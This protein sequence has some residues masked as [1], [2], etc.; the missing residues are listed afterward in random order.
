MPVVGEP[1]RQ[2]IDRYASL[3]VFS[4]T[5]L[6]PRRLSVL[7]APDPN[8]S[9]RAQ[10]RQLLEPHGLTL[11]M[12]DPRT[13]YVAV[14]APEPED[15]PHSEAT[16]NPAPVVQPYIEEVTVYA[17]F[18]VD[19]TD[20]RQSLNQ[21]Q[22][23]LIP[24]TGGDTLRALRILPSV[25][26]DGL[27]AKHRIRG[28]DNNEVLYRLDGVDQY[29]PFHFADVHSLFTAVNPNIID[30]V[31]V[32]VSGFPS[33]FGTRMSGVVDLHLVE[34]ERPLHGT[35]EVSAL[36]AAADARG[37]AGKWSWLVSGRVSLIGDV[38]EVIKV[39][40]EENLAIPRFDDELARLA[41][42]DAN[43]ELVIGVFRTKE[44][45]DVE[46]ENTG[47]RVRAGVSHHD[48]W[49]RWQHD[50]SG[51]LRMSWQASHFSAKRNRNGTIEQGED[52]SGHLDERRSFRTATLANQWRWTP[53]RDTEIN[54]G[55]AYLRH[56]GKFNAS[57]AVRYTPL[58][59]PVQH[60]TWVARDLAANRRGSSGR[61]FAS[62]TRALTTRLTGTAGLRFDWQ[63]AA[64]VRTNEWSGRVA[65]AYKTSPRW[66]VDLDLGRYK[67]PQFLNETQID[68][69]RIE[70]DPPQHADQVNLGVTWSP[71]SRLRLRSDL[72]ARRIHRPW[73]RFRNLYNH[74]ALL[75]ELSDDRYRIEASKARSQGIELA[76]SY[77]GNRFSW[78]LAY[79]RSRSEERI[80]G[81]WHNRS[82]DQPNTLSAHAAWSG[83]RW[84]I[85]LNLA[86]RSGWPI[87]PLVT[88]PAQLPA[89][90]NADRLP[91][92]LSLDAHVARIIPTRRGK[93]EIYGDVT[94][95]TNRRNVAGHL[96][97]PDFSRDDSLSLP[98]I[99]SVGIRWSW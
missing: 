87:T 80:A 65:L 38:L 15:E 91:S 21:Q 85:G 56:H 89:D 48:L 68:E 1:L 34:P 53:R 66:Q 25:T 60:V 70:L 2:A 41:W 98:I 4:S 39:T 73:P 88:H 42:S 71:I 82:W 76:A 28:G 44:T 43:N 77:S 45:V 63:R 3:N 9:P 52:P 51:S 90:I 74:F 30:S 40:G 5:R 55:W 11:V 12:T 58:G 57:L 95:A 19:R 94:N 29:E 59:L 92:Y 83:N 17:P 8:T 99:P 93:I 97:D 6:L 78:K 72:Y 47:E 31:D 32:Y 33:R 26:S 14:A 54:A 96:Y 50:F 24:S 16:A 67:Q 10:I 37:Y 64:D 22:L 86:Y 62:A 75:P 46:R 36:A 20:R 61:A 79:A 69:G 84:R 18:R 27:S 49:A 7:A 81:A 23:N 13:G 35:V